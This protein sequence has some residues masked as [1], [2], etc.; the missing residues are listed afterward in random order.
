MA[1]QLSLSIERRTERQRFIYE[2]NDTQVSVTLRTRLHLSQYLFSTTSCYM[3]HTRWHTSVCGS[4][5]SSL[6]PAAV[7]GPE[8]QS[9]HMKLCIKLSLCS[10]NHVI[11]PVMNMKE[12]SSLMPLSVK[13]SIMQ[14][15][16]QSR[17]CLRCLS[18]VNLTLIKPIMSLLWQLDINQDNITNRTWHYQT[19]ICGWF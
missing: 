15:F 6:Y 13:L 1:V 18:Y 12:A 4:H 16:M 3:Q 8:R 17:H 11:T 10:H 14:L 9:V 19:V 5:K 2:L 7:C